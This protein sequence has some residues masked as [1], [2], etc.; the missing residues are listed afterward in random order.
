MRKILSLL[1]VLLLCTACAQTPTIPE[2][3]SREPEGDTAEE[4]KPVPETADHVLLTLEAPLADGRT[5]TLEAVGRVLDEY[6]CGVREVRIYDGDDLLQTVSVREAIEKVWSFG[7]GVLAEDFY[8]Y[9]ECWTA[10]KTM[11]ALDLNFD[12][13]TDFGLFGWP[14]NNTIPYYYWTWDSDTARYRYAFTL[15]GV[16]VHPETGEVSSE[17]KD[18]TGGVYYRR[19]YYQ[20]D[21]TG[22]LCLVRQEREVYDV[23]NLDVNRGCALETWVP[24]EGA[25]IRPEEQD[26]ADLVLIRRE[27]PVYEVHDDNTASHFTEIWELADGELQM[28]SREEFF[29]E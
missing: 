22:A 24:R 29:D 12:G 15:Q 17:Y 28:T 1:L 6:S 18:G 21:E 26:A 13:N 25:L 23:P 8:D 19:D 3:S 20:P 10:E 2:E 4:T 14:A 11:E 16:E 5:L 7:D 9:T 27:I